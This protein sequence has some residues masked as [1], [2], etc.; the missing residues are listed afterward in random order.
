M[1]KH[2]KGNK[3]PV[4]QNANTAQSSVELAWQ[5]ATTG[6]GYLSSLMQGDASVISLPEVEKDQISES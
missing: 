1:A 2:N 3:A 5:K 6:I 4:A